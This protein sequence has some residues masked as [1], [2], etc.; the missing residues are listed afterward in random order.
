MN[1]LDDFDRIHF[2]DQIVDICNVNIRICT[3]HSGLPSQRETFR[4]HLVS[5]HPKADT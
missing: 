1:N 3:N 2:V 4:I 5:S